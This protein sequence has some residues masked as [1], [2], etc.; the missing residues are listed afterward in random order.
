MTA[1]SNKARILIVDDN[2][3]GI[4]KL[5]EVVAYRSIVESISAI[6]FQISEQNGMF[7]PDEVLNGDLPLDPHFKEALKVYKNGIR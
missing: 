6:A 4:D 2:S 3:E 5:E 1:P 7:T